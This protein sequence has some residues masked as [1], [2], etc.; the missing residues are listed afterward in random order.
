MTITNSYRRS[1][2]S[3][4]NDYHTTDKHINEKWLILK[5]IIAEND[6]YYYLKT[7]LF[8]ALMYYNNIIPLLFLGIDQGLMPI[9]SIS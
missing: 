6:V 7:A 8:V 4:E 1:I 3:H 2:S 5:K 9:L